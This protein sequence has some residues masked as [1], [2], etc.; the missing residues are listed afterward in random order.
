[1][2]KQGRVMEI[3]IQ[4]VAGPFPRGRMNGAVSKNG[5]CFLYHNSAAVLKGGCTSKAFRTV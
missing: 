5:A 4:V 3:T 2:E 1:M